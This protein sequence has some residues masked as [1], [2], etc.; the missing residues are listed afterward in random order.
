M[1]N[2]FF[3]SSVFNWVILPLLIFIARVCDVSLGTV[4]IMLLSRGRK[5]LAPLLG[6][7]EVMIWLLAIR[8]VMFNLTNVACYLAF[9]G[10]FAMG[11]F[12]GMFLEEKLAVGVQVFRIFS[13][14]ETAGALVNAL[15]GHGYGVTTLEAHGTMGK[16]TIIFTIVKRKDIEKIIELINQS[17]PKAFYSISD[18][19]AVSEGVFPARDSSLPG[20]LKFSRHGK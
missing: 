19:R 11:N 15:K 4:R 14:T 12:V 20:F 7:V 17:T 10:G 3:D 8:Q 2:S 18:I 9:A 5:I 1:D 16:I 6:F 13:R